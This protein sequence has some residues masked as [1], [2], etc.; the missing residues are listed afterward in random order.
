[1]NIFVCISFFPSSILLKT[2][3]SQKYKSIHIFYLITDKAMWLPDFITLNSED[4][5]WTPSAHLETS[6]MDLDSVMKQ[7]KRFYKE[8]GVGLLESSESI[9]NK[10]ISI[11]VPKQK[12][13]VLVLGPHHQAKEK[14]LDIYFDKTGG[15]PKIDF[16]NLD[17]IVVTHGNRS[18]QVKGTS[19]IDHCPQLAYLQHSPHLRDSLSLEAALKTTKSLVS[20]I[21]VPQELAPP[22]KTDDETLNASPPS[23]P[24]YKTEVL[25]TLAKAADLILIFF[26]PTGTERPAVTIS[27]S[28][29][30]FQVHQ[31]KVH[32]VLAKAVDNECS[33]EVREDVF[34]DI[35]GGMW[36][37][38]AALSTGHFAPKICCP[39]FTGGKPDDTRF[40]KIIRS[41]E[42][43]LVDGA[44]LQ[45]E[46]DAGEVLKHLT[47]ERTIQRVAD[48]ALISGVI[49]ILMCVIGWTSDASWFRAVA[50]LGILLV[51]FCAFAEARKGKR[52]PKMLIH[53]R[54]AFAQEALAKITKMEDSLDLS[55]SDSDFE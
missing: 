43:E 22:P 1:M 4:S 54:I 12:I 9:P 5:D 53:R 44:L 13:T 11:T 34:V 38:K 42:R 32:L 28:T 35:I 52:K 30:L 15:L 45:L 27:S 23:P 50:A 17:T 6:V 40:W 47:T 16:A 29:S 24:A 14:F 8:E 49:T 39:D 2:N 3:S 21:F 33:N 31:K 55:D 25:R 51:L 48:F 10:L 7:I 18:Q 36:N 20:F 26:D 46:K 37:L 19:V 41:A